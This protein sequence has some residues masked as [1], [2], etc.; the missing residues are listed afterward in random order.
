VVGLNR[1]IFSGETARNSGITETGRIESIYADK[2][3]YGEG[4][5]RVKIRSEEGNAIGTHSIA[6]NMIVGFRKGDWV[7]Y[8]LKPDPQ[9]PHSAYHPSLNIHIEHVP[10][11]PNYRKTPCC[12]YCSE[13]RHRYTTFGPDGCKKYKTIVE[14]SDICDDFGWKKGK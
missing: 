5:K 14:K 7:Y 9:Y 8:D 4:H 2:G 11:P 10:T 13:F 3:W 12:A 6:N 1:S